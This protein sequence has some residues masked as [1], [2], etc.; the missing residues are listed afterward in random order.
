MAQENPITFGLPK[1]RN[2]AEVITLIKNAGYDLPDIDK[3]GRQL[4]H[5][6]HCKR[7]RLVILRDTDIPT[8]IE[9][10]AVDVAVAGKDMLMEEDKDLYEP[11][12]LGFGYCRIA[13]A[14]PKGSLEKYQRSS[15]I[16]VATKFTH[17]TEEFFQKKGIN[18]ELIK[19]HGTQ[20][21]APL[22]GLADYI[23]DLV[24]TGTTLK[25]NG[26]V[27]LEQIGE[28]TA[29]LVV[30]RASLKI[31]HKEILPMIESMKADIEK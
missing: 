30:N 8:Y 2:F 18:A 10:G 12:D 26:L 21:L 11:V 3:K 19:L 6:S 29:R 24:S 14:G 1:G 5:Y 16:S 9:H 15:S 22:I 27:E 17:I 28:I 20:E 25:E 4:I 7:L 13:V 31:R 23:V